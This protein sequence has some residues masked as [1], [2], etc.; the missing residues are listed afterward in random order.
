MPLLLTWLQLMLCHQPTPLSCLAN[1]SPPQLPGLT[2][3]L[4][5]TWVHSF[6]T[7]GTWGHVCNVSDVPLIVLGQ[8]ERRPAI[9][10][11]TLSSEFFSAL[12]RGG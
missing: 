3:A 11:L 8:L 10:A 1:P 9:H 7:Q 6:F 12:F 5:I 4:R 2:L